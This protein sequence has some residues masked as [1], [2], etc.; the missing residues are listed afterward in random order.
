MGRGAGDVLLQEV[1]RRP[2]QFPPGG[3]F[4]S[5]PGS[6]RF[7]LTVQQQ[8]THPT[9]PFLCDEFADEGAWARGCARAFA[10]MADVARPSSHVSVTGV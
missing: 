9:R 5:S 10:V 6:F 1:G 7:L 3:A 8:V 4:G 2:N